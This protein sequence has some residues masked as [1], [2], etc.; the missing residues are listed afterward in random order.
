MQQ[1]AAKKLGSMHAVLASTTTAGDQGVSVAI[2]STYDSWVD[3]G[4]PGDRVY[5]LMKV[6]NETNGTT[7]DSV[8][9]VLKWDTPAMA[10]QAGQGVGSHAAVWS[11]DG[12]DQM[13][14]AFKP[15]LSAASDVA[16]PAL[17]TRTG[18]DRID[19]TAATKYEGTVAGMKTMVWVRS[20]G[21][22]LQQKET[23]D[24]NFST[25]SA[26]PGDTGNLNMTM[27][28]TQS[29]NQFGEAPQL[30]AVKVGDHCS[31]SS[32]TG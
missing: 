3:N 12:V 9:Y 24:P 18:T 7:A 20:D 29:W 22:W 23:G 8:A 15:M 5:L 27:S 1:T 11:T 16:S 10:C 13:I 30:P 14:N 2:T 21:V 17:M 28:I 19:G 32:P 4:H 26:S 25:D 6:H 31:E